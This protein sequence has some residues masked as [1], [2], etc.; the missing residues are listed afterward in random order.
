MTLDCSPG[1]SEFEFGPVVQE[2][3][4]RAGFFCILVAEESGESAWRQWGAFKL[5]LLSVL[6]PWL[7]F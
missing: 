3:S 6:R 4:L 5:A 2:A 1:S 7:L